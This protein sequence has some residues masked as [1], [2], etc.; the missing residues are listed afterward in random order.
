MFA[1]LFINLLQYQSGFCD[2][3]QGS[4]EGIN[5]VDCAHLGG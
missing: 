1:I 5:R 3:I 2:N 4:V